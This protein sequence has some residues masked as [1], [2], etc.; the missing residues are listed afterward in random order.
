MGEIIFYN[1]WNPKFTKEFLGIVNMAVEKW[2][3]KVNYKG[4]PANGA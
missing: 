4:G 1:R 2:D 3:S